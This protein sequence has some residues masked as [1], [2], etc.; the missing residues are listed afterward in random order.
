M[1]QKFTNLS[2]DALLKHIAEAKLYRVM[3]SFPF[4]LQIP[5]L[6]VGCS[7]SRCTNCSGAVAYCDHVCTHC[8]APFVGPYGLPQ[9]N[10]WLQ[11]N[12]ADKLNYA[13]DM[14]WKNNHARIAY[15]NVPHAPLN[16]GEAVKIERLGLY[17]QELFERI[18]QIKSKDL[19]HA[20]ALFI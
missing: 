4:A 7:G 18:H 5:D 19:I 20:C 2:S 13:R 8:F 14:Y 17:E 3:D 9:I 6:E 12:V 16:M 15:E 11:L 10:E 1:V